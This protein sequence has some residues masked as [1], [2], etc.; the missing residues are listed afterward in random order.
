MAKLSAIEIYKNLP[1][2][3]CGE[4]GFPT[5]LAFAM[6]LAN[7]QASLDQCPH[8]TEEAK[9]ALSAAAAPPMRKVA[10]GKNENKVEIGGET[11]LFRHEEKFHRP[12]GIA[13]KVKDSL[14]DDELEDKVE[15]I[16][17]LAFE[18]IGEIIRVNLIAIEHSDTSPKEYAKRVEGI[19]KRTNLPLIL[20]SQDAAT[21]KAALERCAD[22]RPLI[23]A[24]SEKNWEEMTSLAKDASC[25]LAVEGG[26]LESLASLTEQINQAGVEE[27]I[28]APTSE[29]MLGYLEKLT[30]IRRLALE[31]TFRPLGYPVITFTN[32]EDPF[33]E[34][35]QAANSILKYGSILVME[36]MEPWRILPPLTVRQHIYIDPQVPNAVEAKLYEIGEPGPDSPVLFTT[37]FSLTYF[38]VAGEVE[39][40][41]V[42]TYISVMDTEGLG[43]LNAYADDRLSGETVVE[44]LKKQG[45]MDKVNHGKLIIPGLVAVLRMKIQEEGGWEVIV[46]PEDAASIPRFLK[47]EWPKLRSAVQE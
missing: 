1:K 43:V 3:N 12:T 30:L 19:G 16:N 28:L 29:D 15:Q 2:T 46:G 11:V 34:V 18:R 41:R 23:Y 22:S 9:Q 8:V 25:P 32:D 47:Q 37:N 27:L 26:D 6:Q 31:K 44:T 13:I 21:M 17:S 5:C 39:D 45:V 10:I 14:S 24:A 33:Q 42:P 35:A 36:G 7:K 40:C 4:C 38:T 20:L